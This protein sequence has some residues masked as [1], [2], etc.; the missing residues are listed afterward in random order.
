MKIRVL[1]AIAFAVLL[2][3]CVGMPDAEGWRSG[4]KSEFMEILEKDKYASICNQ[5]ALYTKVKQSRDSKLMSKLLVA[6]TENLANG[7]ID[8]QR[9][10]AIQEA[11]REEKIKTHY[12]VYRQKV[13]KSDIINMERKTT[14]FTGWMKAT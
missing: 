5:Q 2:S 14:S 9:F 3:G 13:T 12:E 10:E 6:Y 7:C 8:L 11:K 4:R 1:V